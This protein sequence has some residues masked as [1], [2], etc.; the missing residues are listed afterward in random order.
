MRVPTTRP[1]ARP[2]NARPSSPLPI[3]TWCLIAGMRVPHV[4]NAAA[5]IM[6]TAQTLIRARRSIGSGKR[7]ALDG[8]E[9]LRDL[10][11]ERPSFVD[12][13]VGEGTCT[14]E[15]RTIAPKLGEPQIGQTRLARSQQ[16]SAA[17]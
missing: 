13:L 6:N 12:Q 16:L 3:P 1:I 15:E 11:G 17:A 2:E 14:L 4:P 8:G 10:V 5:W 9:S 7:F